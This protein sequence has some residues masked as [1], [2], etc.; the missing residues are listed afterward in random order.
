M[1]T[2]GK[3]LVFVNLF[4]ALVIGGFLAVDFARRTNWK[5]AF[6]NAESQIKIARNN[7]DTLVESNKKHLAE[8]S[9]L[10][11]NLA[12]QEKKIKTVEDDLKNKLKTEQMAKSVSEQKAN[13]QAIQLTEAVAEAK[14]RADEVANLSQVIKTREQFILK[15]EDDVSK[16]KTDTLAAQNDR[17]NAQRRSSALYDQVR[18]LQKELAKA[19]TST[20]AGAVRGIASLK[21]PMNYVK[22]KIESIDS[23]DSS[24]VQ[25]SVGSDHGLSDGNTLDVFRLRPAP[26]YLGTLVIVDAQH[27]KAVGRLLPSEV[28][29]RRVELRVGD[30]VASQISR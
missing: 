20:G 7:T 23:K 12:A 16:Y 18:E 17:D 10:N 24:L 28:R 1:N 3:T 6:D 25:I 8:I 9:R 30:E 19:S 27:H 2:M 4:F 22:G 14:R 29:T 21:P 11:A 26:E 13:L 15:L 5:A